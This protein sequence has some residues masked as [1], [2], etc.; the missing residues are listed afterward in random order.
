MIALVLFI[1]CY[2]LFIMLSARNQLSKHIFDI[3]A[4]TRI[5][6][7]PEMTSSVGGGAGAS[8]VI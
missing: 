7:I 5:Y 1:S 6:E 3:A 2:I 4:K 8:C